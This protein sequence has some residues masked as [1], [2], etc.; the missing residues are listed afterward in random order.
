MYRSFVAI[1]ILIGLNMAAMTQAKPARAEGLKIAVVAPTE[2]PFALLGKQILDGAQFQAQDH[3]SEIIPINETCETTDSEALAK[4]VVAAGAE[5]AIGFLC[6]ESL[7]AVLP[8]LAESS[9]PAL[10]LSVRSDILMEDALRKKWPFFRLVPNA[11]AEAARITDIILSRWKGEPL[12]L[13]DDGTIHGREL[14][15]SVREALAAIGLTPVFND[16]YRPA[17]EQQ[18]ALVRRLAKSGATHVF[19][20]GDRIDTAIIARDAKSESFDLTLMGGEALSAADQT[21]PLENGVLAVTLPDYATLPEAKAVSA[22]MKAT[23]LVPEGYVLPSFAAVSLLE[24]AKDQ[25]AKDG[26]GLLDA[27]AKGP[28]PTALGAIRFDKGHELADNPYRLMRWQDGR[29]VPVSP[30]PPAD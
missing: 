5:A 12:G 6:T 18:V 7:E 9:M 16:T 29:F 2:G 13:I 22:A 1:L 3:G 28:Y 24:L 11:K 19:T 20:G 10:S 26:T 17:Q 30:L 8:A 14:V 15:E 25:A 21:V 4:A 23:G 27:L